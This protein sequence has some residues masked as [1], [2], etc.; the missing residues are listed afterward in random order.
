MTFRFIIVSKRRPS[1]TTSLNLANPAEPLEAVGSPEFCWEQQRFY[2]RSYL[3][4]HL[5]HPRK[6]ADTES[7]SG[8][9]DVGLLA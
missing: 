6:H 9:G 5:F 4:A 2:A 7:S 3:S 8:S 1:D